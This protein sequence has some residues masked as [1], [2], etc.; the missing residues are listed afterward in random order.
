MDKY[1]VNR[2][3]RRI[4]REKKLKQKDVAEKAGFSAQTM[5]N[6]LRNKRH[7]Y[8]DEL[9]P[10]CMAIGVSMRKV[11]AEWEAEQKGS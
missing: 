5:S 2:V 11:I 3:L 9:C 7:I 8:A 6:I 4:I 1:I 10:L